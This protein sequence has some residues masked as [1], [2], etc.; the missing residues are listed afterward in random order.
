M[1]EYCMYMLLSFYLTLPERLEETLAQT[2]RTVLSETWPLLKFTTVIVKA[3][4]NVYWK[5]GSV[6]VKPWYQ[7]TETIKYLDDLTF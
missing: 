4:W 6:G 3:V 7:D 1:A 2:L 5:I